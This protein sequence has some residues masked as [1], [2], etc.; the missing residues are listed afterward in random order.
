MMPWAHLARALLGWACAGAVLVPANADQSS[1][2]QVPLKSA[3]GRALP[4][5]DR[6]IVYLR[7]DNRPTPAEIGR[8]Q[9]MSVSTASAL[10]IAARMNLTPLRR[11]GDG[12]HV[13]RLD[14]PILESEVERMAEVLRRNPN[15]AHAEADRRKRVLQAGCPSLSTAEC[16]S[17]QWNLQDP[18]G[19]IN[20]S[21]A[22]SVMTESTGVRV[23]VIDTGILRGHPDL[24]ND[25]L[26]DGYD[27]ISRDQDGSASTANDG[28]GRD[29]DETDP[30]NA[31]SQSD[32]NSNSLFASCSVEDSDWHGTHTTGIIAAATNSVG[33]RGINRNARILPIRALGKCGGYTSD[34]VDGMRWAAGLNVPGVRANVTP[35]QVLNLSLGGSGNCSTIEQNAINDVLAAGVKAIVTAAGNDNG[36]DAST[37]S[38]GNCNGVITIAAT[39]RA[40]SRAAYSNQGTLVALSAPGGYFVTNGVAQNGILSLFNAG[41]TAPQ[42]FPSGADYAYVI[43]TSEATAHVSGVVSLML[44]AHPAL[45]ATQVR[46]LLRSSARAFP[47]GS[48]CTTTNCGAGIVD[49]HA[50]VLAAYAA[51]GG[52]GTGS[53]PSVDL[54]TSATVSVSGSTTT[55]VA[56]AWNNSVLTANGAT[57]VASIPTRFT[58]GSGVSC[59]PSGT[60]SC[61]GAGTISGDTVTFSGLILPADTGAA[62]SADTNYVTITLTGSATELAN[63]VFAGSIAVPSSQSDSTRSNNGVSV[64]VIAANQTGTVEACDSG[65]GT[66]SSGGGGGGGGGGCVLNRDRNVDPLLPILLLAAGFMLIRRRR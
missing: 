36:A 5:T 20:I 63:A 6:M 53:G 62:T 2:P 42:A 41:T 52:A 39:D 65:G 64:D 24:P 38:P 3:A 58:L 49:A 13:M 21:N 8:L 10:S 18:T 34:I 12:G 48:T 16:F 43:G 29:D 60:A 15:I 22:W 46:N 35:A 27:F 7:E 59:T 57:F 45:S 14:R 51:S 1:I 37:N 19:G 25:R 55:F 32:I 9:P 17:L 44:S 54:A 4:T 30:G 47:G 26:L 28:C 40:G 33:I 50:A 31:V 11:M 61:G 66:L 56:K 23:A